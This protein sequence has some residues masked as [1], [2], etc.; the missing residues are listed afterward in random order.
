MWIIHNNYV[1]NIPEKWLVK[2]PGGYD[3]IAT[4]AGGD[5]TDAFEVASNIGHSE[6]DSLCWLNLT[7]RGLKLLGMHVLGIL[8][9]SLETNTRLIVLYCIAYYDFT[10]DE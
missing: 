6:Y 5:A 4:L 1:F 2:H 8:T 3:A 10:L 9:L 7:A